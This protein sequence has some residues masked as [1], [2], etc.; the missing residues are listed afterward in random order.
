MPST[1]TSQ[2]IKKSSVPVQTA[3]QIA[4]GY[5]VSGGKCLQ[6]VGKIL[7]LQSVGKKMLE[8]GIEQTDPEVAATIIS[9]SIGTILTQRREARAQGDEKSAL[10]LTDRLRRLQAVRDRIH[11]GDAEAIGSVL[12]GAVG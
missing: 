12:R 1:L 2:D 11:S 6:G 8:R 4:Y 9:E 5:D 7:E 10:T 3:E